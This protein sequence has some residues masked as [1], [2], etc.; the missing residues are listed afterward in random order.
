MHIIDFVLALHDDVVKRILK[1]AVVN[2]HDDGKLKED[3]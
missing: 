2:V 1:G 3:T